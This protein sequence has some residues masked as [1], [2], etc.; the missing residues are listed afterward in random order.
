MTTKHLRI[1]ETRLRRA[2][3][4]L[5]EDIEDKSTPLWVKSFIKIWNYNKQYWIV[6]ALDQGN[7][8]VRFKTMNHLAGFCRVCGVK[9]DY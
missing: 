7:I 5:E 8:E 2:G 6:D 4:V 9:C 3:F 1:T